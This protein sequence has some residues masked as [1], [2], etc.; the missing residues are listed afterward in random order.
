MTNSDYLR[1]QQARIS[2]A[3]ES[4]RV[5]DQLIVARA[6]RERVASQE[7][8]A[9]QRIAPAEAPPAAPALVDPYLKA[10]ANRL[11]FGK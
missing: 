7:R 2:R 8:I 6:A 4:A 3:R 1:E 5:L 10:I 11:Q 9:P